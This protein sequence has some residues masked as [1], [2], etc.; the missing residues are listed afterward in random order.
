MGPRGQTIGF[1]KER[2][3]VNDTGLLA[4]HADSRIDYAPTHP[5]LTVAFPILVESIPLHNAQ[6]V[7][8]SPRLDIQIG[9]PHAFQASAYSQGSVG[10]SGGSSSSAS[11][12]TDVCF[13]PDGDA[14]AV[15]DDGGPVACLPLRN[16]LARLCAGHDLLLGPEQ[17]RADDR[18]DLV[19]RR[20]G[21][22]NANHKASPLFSLIVL[23]TCS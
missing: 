21:V 16:P 4:P 22:M 18:Y 7:R 5:S 14:G 15:I 11:A 17:C 10:S 8:W 20:R 19:S 12:D 2:Y 13:H 3:L 23:P 1:G 9:Q 6:R